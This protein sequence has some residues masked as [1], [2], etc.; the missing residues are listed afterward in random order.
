MGSTSRPKHRDHTLGTQIPPADLITGAPGL[1]GSHLARRFADQG[2][3][4]G[5]F[6]C[7][8]TAA[9]RLLG[10]QPQLPLADAL[11]RNLDAHLGT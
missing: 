5:R 8:A 4:L 11:S 2:H 10:W 9:V 3:P 1:L 7:R 6:R